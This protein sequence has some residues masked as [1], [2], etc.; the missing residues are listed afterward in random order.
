MR[1][2]C[3]FRSFFGNDLKTS[4]NFGAHCNQLTA[5]TAASGDH[6]IQSQVTT[7]K[8]LFCNSIIL[9]IDYLQMVFYLSML[10]CTT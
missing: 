7:I 10:Y 3:H 9:E 6:V 8:A 2:S 4:M 5:V 1:I